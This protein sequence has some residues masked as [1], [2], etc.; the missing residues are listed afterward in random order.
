MA[1]LCW[2]LH[3]QSSFVNGAKNPI[4]S[5]ILSENPSIYI[6]GC[7]CHVVHNTVKKAGKGFLEV[8]VG[9]ILL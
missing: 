3:W 7:P 9:L 4:A 6:H 2:S 5:R 1:E 8:S